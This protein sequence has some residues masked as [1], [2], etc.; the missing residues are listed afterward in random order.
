M[1]LFLYGLAMGLG[2]LLAVLLGR[3][4]VLPGVPQSSTSAPVPAGLDGERI[5]R[6]LGEAI[7]FATISHQVGAGEQALRDSRVAF[8]G[9][10]DW[11]SRRYP[12]VATQLQREQV[13]DSLLYTWVGRNPALP[14]VLLMAHQDVVPVVRGSEGSWLQPPFS[15]ALADGYVWGRGALDIKSSLVT[16]MEATEALLA[17]GFQ[18]DR[19]LLLA[20][21]HDEEIGGTQGNRRI[22]ELLRQRGTRLSWVVDE[23]GFI[24]QGLVAGMSQ[25]SAFVGIAEKGYLSLKLKATASGGHSSAPPVFAQTAIG[26]LTEALRRIGEQ[27]FPLALDS[28][29]EQTLAALAPYQEGAR[30]L[31]FANQWLFA[32]L[33]QQVLGNSKEFATQMHTTVAPTIIRGGVKDNVLPPS[34]MAVINLRI[35][36]RDSQASV[37]EHIRGVVADQQVEVLPLPGGWEPSAIS[38]ADSDEFRLLERTIQESFANTVVVPNL[39]AAATDSRH[40]L[41]LTDQVFRFVPRQLSAAEMA[42]IHGANERIAV[43]NLVQMAGFYYRL[44]Q[45]QGGHTN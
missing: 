29:V 19:T 33:M 1:K 44:L 28:T 20:F 7:R 8:A 13:G 12:H 24:G 43:K 6:H 26:R 39:T 15:G 22:A 9:L 18:P 4:L 31:V 34:A 3:T 38:R 11:L 32:P 27:P 2:L 23:G 25:D 42:G 35:H 37:L 36:P 10:H 5:A 17:R 41:G 40:Y 45:A 14:A 21:G 30:R 16:I